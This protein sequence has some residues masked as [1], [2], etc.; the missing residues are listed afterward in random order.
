MK[1]EKLY[2][3]HTFSLPYLWLVLHHGV[4]LKPSPKKKRKKNPV[5]ESVFIFLKVFI[6]FER[7]RES[8]RTCVSWGGAQREGETEREREPARSL[9]RGSNP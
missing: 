2:I 1:L 9:I 6:Y 7:E 8:M 4:H 5:P 3:A